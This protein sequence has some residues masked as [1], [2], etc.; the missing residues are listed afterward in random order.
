MI[1]TEVTFNN[2]KRDDEKNVS[3]RASISLASRR[4]TVKSGSVFGRPSSMRTERF[5]RRAMQSRRC[6]RKCGDTASS[7]KNIETR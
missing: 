1:D 7:S 6:W 5:A 3:Y 4:R 2:K